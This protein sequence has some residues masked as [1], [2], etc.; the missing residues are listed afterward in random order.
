MSDPL[1]RNGR[2]ARSTTLRLGNHA[3][4]MQRPERVTD[5]DPNPGQIV[6]RGQVRGQFVAETRVEPQDLPTEQRIHRSIAGEETDEIGVAL[7]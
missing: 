6:R 1:D 4:E 7:V 3:A 5:L 2:D